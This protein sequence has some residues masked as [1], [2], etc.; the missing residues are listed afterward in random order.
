MT[1]LG[2]A[3]GS[4]IG[5]SSQTAAYS[6]T[7]AT[8]TPSSLLA[9]DNTVLASL[10]AFGVAVNEANNE[11]YLS[12]GQGDLKVFTE[13][14]AAFLNS[15]SSTATFASPTGLFWDGRAAELKLYVAQQTVNTGSG[16]VDVLKRAADGS[17]SRPSLGALPNPIVSA[18]NLQFPSAVWVAVP[19]GAGNA[20]LWVANSSKP[21][22]APGGG[23]AGAARIDL[24]TGVVALFSNSGD[25]YS[26]AAVVTDSPSP[27]TAS[28]AR[29]YLG[30]SPN[31]AAASG[32]FGVEV[33]S[34]ALTGV[35]ALLGTLQVV[36]G[37][38]RIGGLAW[39]N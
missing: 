2:L 33:L 16:Y 21:S 23:G 32:N 34:G 31:G 17:F 37:T 10:Q 1:N 20:M 5:G 11:V 26:P 8:S 29:V 6:M 24:T 18:G 19:S 13:S 35:P 14:T 15:A 38:H 27:A 4:S 22:G 7:T 28:S 30:V 39:C 25:F 9:I 36:G 12:D 3:G